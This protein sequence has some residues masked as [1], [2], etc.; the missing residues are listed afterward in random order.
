MDGHIVLTKVFKN[1]SNFSAHF[2]VH[3]GSAIN[4]FF[5]LEAVLGIRIRRILM[6]FGL[7]DP[8]QDP[9]IRGTDP[10]PSLF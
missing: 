2:F 4:I 3:I 1:H 9:L 5:S 8:D 7:Q 10:D 6:F